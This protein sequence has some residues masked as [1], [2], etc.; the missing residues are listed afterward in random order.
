[1]HSD[2]FS[3]IRRRRAPRADVAD[4]LRVHLASA[5]PDKTAEMREILLGAL[6]DRLELLDRPGFVGEVEEDGETLEDNARS[7]AVAICRATNRAAV[8]DDTGLEVDALGGSPGVRSA[9]YAGDH[10]SYGDNVDK[11]LT[12][13]AGVS[14]RTARFRT[15]ALVAF[16]DGSELVA[17]GLTH[18]TIALQPR[19]SS[20]FGYDPVFVPANGDG[21]TFA[22]L[23]AREKHDCSHRG[24]A[25]RAL[26]QLLVER[27]L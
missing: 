18:G 3:K 22:E 19:G 5:N 17:E 10:A 27:S 13:L 12:D 2:R 15:V 11:L 4:T 1:M 24:R 7:K 23:T 14:N 8:S 20:G 25:F 9:R 21:R 16:P 26:A 6:G